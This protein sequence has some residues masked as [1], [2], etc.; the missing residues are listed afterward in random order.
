MRSEK[1]TSNLQGKAQ[2]KPSKEAIY[3]K[4]IYRCSKKQ[5]DQKYQVFPLVD[6]YKLKGS[7][8]FLFVLSS[9]QVTEF[10]YMS[11]APCHWYLPNKSCYIITISSILKLSSI[12]ASVRNLTTSS[13]DAWNNLVCDCEKHNHSTDSLLTGHFSL[14]GHFCLSIFISETVLLQ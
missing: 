2:N 14:L 6:N 7:S 9:T 8:R 4:G 5:N 1:I 10:I 12:D 3:Q 13:V 11:P